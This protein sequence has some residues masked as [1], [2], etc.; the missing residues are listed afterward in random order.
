MLKVIGLCTRLAQMPQAQPGNA[1]AVPALGRLSA[2]AS[3]HITASAKVTA[4]RV[5]VFGIPSTQYAY[6]NRLVHI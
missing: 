6:D 2:A 5:Y 1:F 3:G 4:S